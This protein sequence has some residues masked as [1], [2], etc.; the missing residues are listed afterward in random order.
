M[1]GGGSQAYETAVRLAD[2]ELRRLVDELRTQGLWEQS[3]LLVVSDHGHD[4]NLREITLSDAFDAAGIDSSTYLIVQPLGVSILQV[5]LADRTD[6]G[7]FELLRRMRQAVVAVEGVDEALYREENS[8]DGGAHSLGGVHPGWHYGGERAG[9]LVVTAQP[10]YRFTDPAATGN[11]LPGNPIPGNHGSPNTL[12]NFF[13]V[14][15]GGSLV[16]HH[17]LSG[18]VA[19]RFDDTLPNAQNQPENVDVAP[20]V[21]GLLGLFAPPGS[22]GRFLGE[23]FDDARLRALSAPPAAPRVR[24]PLL[25][26]GSRTRLYRISW[27][28]ERRGEYDVSIRRRGSGWRRLQRRS[29]QTARRLRLRAGERYAVRARS[30]AASGVHSPWRTRTIRVPATR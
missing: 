4:E 27:A 8:A 26:R 18:H 5:Y 19:Q 22:E 21:A 14:V 3:V 30:R 28:D 6:P 23:A 24:L 1:F 29:Q 11:S 15:G 7:R 9:D 12:D 13:A 20:T 2:D 17:S 16:Q 10:G 25:G